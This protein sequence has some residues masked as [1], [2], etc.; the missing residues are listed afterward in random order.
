[1]GVPSFHLGF[2]IMSG[3]VGGEFR[4]LLGQYQDTQCGLKAFRSDVARGLFAAGRLDGFAFDIELFH[5]IERNHL[6][7]ATAPVE[8]R[9][10]STSSVRTVLDGWRLVRDVVRVRRWARAGVYAVALD[11]PARAD[12]H[13]TDSAGRPIA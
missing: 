8:V 13:V 4:L 12:A 7:L 1:M 5:L 11:L 6:S 9:N 2:Q 3:I 10:T